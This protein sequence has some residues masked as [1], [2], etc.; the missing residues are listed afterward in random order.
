MDLSCDL[1]QCGGLL[2][3][4]REQCKACMEMLCDNSLK[5]F[6]IRKSLVKPLMLM[7]EEML[8]LLPPGLEKHIPFPVPFTQ[9]RG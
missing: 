2:P 8:L 5:F 3:P 6:I 9:L 1:A 7:N 4:L